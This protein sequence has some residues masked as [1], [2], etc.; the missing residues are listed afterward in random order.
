LGTF[1]NNLTTR[2]Y[3]QPLYQRGAMEDDFGVRYHFNQIRS[4]NNPN[5]ISIQSHNVD[6]E[7]DE[8]NMIYVQTDIIGAFRCI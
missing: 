6:E 5:P 2:P 3:T 4:Y 7:E 8:P 1:K